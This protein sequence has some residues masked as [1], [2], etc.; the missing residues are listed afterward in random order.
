M[1]RYCVLR[2]SCDPRWGVR[3]YNMCENELHTNIT[4]NSSKMEVEV[5]F[6]ISTSCMTKRLVK[7]RNCSTVHFMIVVISH[8]SKVFSSWKYNWINR[9]KGTSIC[10]YK[11]R[12]KL[13]MFWGG[14]REI[15]WIVIVFSKILKLFEWDGEKVNRIKVYWNFWEGCDYVLHQ[16]KKTL[17]GNK[18]S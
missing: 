11:R 12:V 1:H 14:Q 10:L 13:F 6:Y 3:T 15:D 17:K 16:E 5:L 7:S 18:P 9:Y 8:F 2:Y 4:N